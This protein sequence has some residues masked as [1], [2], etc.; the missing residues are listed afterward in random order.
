MKKLVTMREALESPAYFGSTDMLG[1]ES[2]AA[3]R[4]ILLA[5]VGE[6][7]TDDERTIFRTLTDRERE[8]LEPVRE[9]WGAIGRR[10]GKSRG[11]GT[12]AAYLAG[13]CDYRAMLAPGQRGRLP[14]VAASKDQADEVMAYTLGAFEQSAALKPLIASAIERTLS[15]HSLID[16]Q[17]RALSFR[18]LR[19]PTSIAVICDEIAYW[20]SD[21]S[22]TPDAEVLKALRPSLATTNGP[23]IAI[24]SPYAKKGVL[25]AAY[26]KDFGAEGRPSRLVAKGPTQLFNPAIDQ[27]FLDDA[28]ADDPVAARA[29]YGA[30]WRDDISAFISSDVVEAAIVQGRY[31]LPMVDGLQY[32]AFTDT[33]GGGGGDSFTL[34]IAHRE[35]I[36]PE[37][38]SVLDL[39]HEIPPPFNPDQATAEMTSILKSYGLQRVIGDAYGGTW[40]AERFKAHGITYEL[41]T[42]IKLNANVQ[43]VTNEGPLY[44]SEIYKT[45]LPM[46]NAGRV[47]LLDNKKLVTQLLS[48]ERRV[49]RSGQDSINHPD[50]GHDD[51]INAA[52]G[53]LVLAGHARRPMVISDAV[54]AR[55]STFGAQQMA[56][57]NRGG[58]R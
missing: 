24:S 29:E 39:V 7:L 1:G 13:C 52:A 15:L 33:A 10:G 26:V 35:G 56:A 30:E 11:V 4:T 27:A 18:N 28:Y 23:L 2:W 6:P 17:V 19:G 32:T 41:S 43:G 16:I 38:R 55:S 45:L 51:V 12:L 31:A 21:E 36:G 57:M 3:W 58:F 8:P 37:A 40:P 49:T 34:G 47:A 9:F 54:L 53:A 5:I 44:R 25:W 48:L 42:K 20:R 14:I 22:A 46:L 50:R